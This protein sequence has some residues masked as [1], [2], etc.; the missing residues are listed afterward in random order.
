MGV[1]DNDPRINKNPVA[2]PFLLCAQHGRMLDGESISLN[3]T[4]PLYARRRFLFIAANVDGVFHLTEV[5][6]FAGMS[7]HSFVHIETVFPATYVVRL[8]NND[9]TAS[10]ISTC[11]VA[12]VILLLSRSCLYGY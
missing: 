8:T 1:T 6:V 7:D 10:V 4:H 9:G 12:I 11:G 3:C 2:S 5:E